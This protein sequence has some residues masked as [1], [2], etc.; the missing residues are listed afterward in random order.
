VHPN[1]G[2][3]GGD[4]SSSVGRGMGSFGDRR[5]VP[6]RSA[7]AFGPG[8]RWYGGVPLVPSDRRRRRRGAWSWRLVGRCLVAP[9]LQRRALLH[10]VGR[11]LVVGRQREGGVGP[12]R[13][14]AGGIP[15]RH[16]AGI[17]WYGGAYAVPLSRASEGSWGLW[18]HWRR[19]GVCCLCPPSHW[20]WPLSV[21]PSPGSWRALVAKLASRACARRLGCGCVDETVVGV[22][23][24]A[25]R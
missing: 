23:C 16:S 11:S 2:C 13:V 19:G 22:V 20:V 25:W 5:R 8:G 7:R 17:G 10:D 15:S 9:R 4:A 12:Y 1:G 18:A 21:V 24:A 14:V 6:V 3:G